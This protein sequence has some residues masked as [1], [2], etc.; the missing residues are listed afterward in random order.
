MITVIVYFKLTDGMTRE[1]IIPKFEQTAQNGMIIKIWFS[2]TISLTLIGE[3]LGEY[4]WKEKMHAEIWLGAE[5]RKMVKENYGEEPTFQFFET[6]IIVDNITG[7][8]TKE[9]DLFI[10]IMYLK[11]KRTKLKFYF[12]KFSPFSRWLLSAQYFK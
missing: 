4:L 7:Y 3:L 10:K 12:I 9:W 8:I 6:P 5:F 2:K 1:E 11:H